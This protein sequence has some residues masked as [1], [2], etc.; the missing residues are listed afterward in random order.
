MQSYTYGN[1][2]VMVGVLAGVATIVA[3]PF[4][5][6]RVQSKPIWR[7]IVKKSKGMAGSA[8]DVSAASHKTDLKKYILGV[9]VRDC[10]NKR[11]LIN[12]NLLLWVYSIVQLTFIIKA[13]VDNN[14]VI[15]GVVSKNSVGLMTVLPIVTGLLFIS[16]FNYVRLLNKYQKEFEAIESLTSTFNSTKGRLTIKKVSDLSDDELEGLSVSATQNS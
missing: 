8:E 5:V 11:L 13:I 10:E 14:W 16:I 1:I 7:D 4:I 3:L 9:W 2:A 6:E 15:D 12:L